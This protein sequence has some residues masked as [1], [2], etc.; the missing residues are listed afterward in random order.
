MTDPSEIPW[1]ADTESEPDAFDEV[2]KLSTTY[3]THLPKEST[4]C[5]K[6]TLKDLFSERLQSKLV[7]TD[8]EATSKALQVEADL[9]SH[10]LTRFSIVGNDQ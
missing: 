1:T 5:Q 6:Y 10:Q 2:V 4:W 9:F 8:L 3:H 7:W